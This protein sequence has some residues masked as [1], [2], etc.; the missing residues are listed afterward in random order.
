MDT[1]EPDTKPAPTLHL[2]KLSSEKRTAKSVKNNVAIGAPATVLMVGGWLTGVSVAGA[3]SSISPSGGPSPVAAFGKT[4]EGTTYGQ[5]DQ[6]LRGDANARPT[7]VM[8]TTDDGRNGYAY[9][10]EL[11]PSHFASNPAEASRLS[12]DQPYKVN[13]Y[14]SNGKTRLG[15]ITVNRLSGE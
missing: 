8:V 6:S 1:T 7:L 4:A 5:I 10:R 11:L 12:T 3:S 13:V 14:A 9:M 2:S 15:S